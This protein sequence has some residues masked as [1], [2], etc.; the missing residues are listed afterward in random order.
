M[1]KVQNQ[2]D[3]PKGGADINERQNHAHRKCPFDFP[4]FSS[5]SSHFFKQAFQD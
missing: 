5:K 3:G 2:G 1:I 4:P